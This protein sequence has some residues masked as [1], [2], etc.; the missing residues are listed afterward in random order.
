MSRLYLK[1]KGNIVKLLAP[2]SHL[3]QT[4]KEPKESGQLREI[5][6]F[7]HKYVL[8]HNFRKKIQNDFIVKI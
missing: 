3:N 2:E 4:S 7:F 5:T 8:G 6:L 1:S